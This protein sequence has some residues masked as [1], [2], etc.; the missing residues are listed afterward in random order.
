MENVELK[1][2]K[3]KRKHTSEVLAGEAS[4]NRKNDAGNSGS[5]VNGAAKPEPYEKKK[6]KHRQQDKVGKSD[7]V[8]DV[9][10]NVGED[11][12]NTATLASGDALGDENKLE[13]ES[14]QLGREGQEED[15]KEEKEQLHTIATTINNDA[16][17]DT[18]MPSH[19][20][21]RLPSTG[22]GPKDFK[23]LNLSSKT[24]EAISVRIFLLRG[25]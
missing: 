5:P 21:L 4:T 10:V 2:R 6:K 19:S 1:S 16:P 3:R 11:K 14:L 13:D 8:E 25:V 23:D 24:M 15:E 20:A 9:Q 18:D 12:E 17:T 22:S 7:T